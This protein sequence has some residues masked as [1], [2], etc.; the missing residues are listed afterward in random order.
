MKTVGMITIGQSPRDDIVPEMEKL[1]GPGVRVREAGALDGLARAEVAALA[2]RGGEDALTTRLRDG[3]DV[4]VAKRAILDRIQGCLDALERE[5]D[6]SVVLCTGVFPRFRTARPL[7][8]P[9]RA[10]AGAVQA[11]FDGGHLGVL[12]PIPEQR[13]GA[14]RR[15]SP[16]AERVT[17]AVAS[18]YR[19]HGEL[20][21]AA[22]ELR[23]AAAGLVVMSCMG[24]TPA[25]KAVVRDVAGAPALLPASVVARLLAELL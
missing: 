14:A 6:A 16:L 18:P 23:R 20:V 17:V 22:E 1:L 8:E 4:V 7:L 25:M 3:G 13:E 5:V 11:A 24:Y 12:V 15:W 2:P 19:G 9:D 10:L 21:A